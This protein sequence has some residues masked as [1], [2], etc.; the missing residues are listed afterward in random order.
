MVKSTI[1]QLTCLVSLGLIASIDFRHFVAPNFLTYPCL[2]IGLIGNLLI[3]TNA[4]LFSCLSACLGY[5]LLWCINQGYLKM[6]KQHGIGGGDMKTAAA[7]GACFG[8]ASLLNIVQW[9]ALIAIAHHICLSLHPKR[10]FNT[11]RKI[12]FVPY[13]FCSALLV[14][15]TLHAQQFHCILERMQN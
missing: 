13:L 3:N 9:A 1:I 14:W 5:G 8:W 10:L 6:R 12:P 2:L 4:F 7:I 15:L 11:M